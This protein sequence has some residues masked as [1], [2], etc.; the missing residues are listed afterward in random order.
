MASAVAMVKPP[1]S[2]TACQ[3]SATDRI[4]EG[5]AEQIL[6]SIVESPWRMEMS[7]LLPKEQYVKEE[8][9]KAIQRMESRRRK[10]GC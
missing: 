2:V 7:A 1:L 8:A 5:E 3:G 4:Q 6:K 10:P 9:E